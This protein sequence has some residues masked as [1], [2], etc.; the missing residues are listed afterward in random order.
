MAALLPNLRG[1]H[2]LI[3][4]QTAGLHHV[5]IIFVLLEQKRHGVKLGFLLDDI[6]RHILHVVAIP[7]LIQIEM[8]RRVLSKF[9]DS[10]TNLTSFGVYIRHR[11]KDIIIC[12]D[13]FLGQI[14]VGG[15]FWRPKI[16]ESPYVLTLLPQD[17]TT[18]VI[19]HTE[20]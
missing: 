4:R 7:F 20:D 18:A 9:Q 5:F 6:Q 1:Q 3:K 12:I 16:E 10:Q 15:L 8:I 11:F 17:D 2:L 14:G 19:F 13:L